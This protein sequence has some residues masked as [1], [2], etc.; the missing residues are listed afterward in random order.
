M[1]M[2]ETRSEKVSVSLTP[3]VV[4]RLDAYARSHRWSRS[5]AAS[6]LIEQGLA[7]EEADGTQLRGGN[8]GR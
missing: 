6:V 2:E 7:Q 8:G 3:T 5:T 4:A 1:H